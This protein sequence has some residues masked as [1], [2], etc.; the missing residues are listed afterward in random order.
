[1]NLWRLI[2]Q[3]AVGFVLSLAMQPLPLK[4]GLSGV[5]VKSLK[6]LPSFSNSVRLKLLNSVSPEM[7]S[8]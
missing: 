3:G 4:H 5:I 6:R 1:M 7:G 2:A 8:S